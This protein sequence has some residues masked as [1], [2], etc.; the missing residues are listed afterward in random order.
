MLFVKTEICGC[1]HPLPKMCCGSR[2]LFFYFFIFFCETDVD[3]R[4]RNLWNGCRHPFRYLFWFFCETNVE[5]HFRNLS[6]ECRHPFRYFFFVFLLNGCR[7]PFTEFLKRMSTSISL[8]FLF[9]IFWNRCRNP[10]Q[11]FVKRMSTSISQIPK[12]DFDIRF[13]MLTPHF[14][15]NSLSL[16]SLSL[17]D[18][19]TTT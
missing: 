14:F 16:I 15:H 7:D 13:T 3:I 6:N 1:R 9:F 18:Q 12:A 19:I 8:M 4:F 5:I 11:E 17:G 10:F 2:H